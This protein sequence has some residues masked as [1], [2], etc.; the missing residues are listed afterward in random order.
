[1]TE[2]GDSTIIEQLRDPSGDRVGVIVHMPC[3]RNQLIVKLRREG[4]LW[5]SRQGWIGRETA[6]M[7]D[8]TSR[9]DKTE[10]D[11][12]A[13]WAAEIET[14]E[15]LHTSCGDPV[16][17]GKCIWNAEMQTDAQAP[18]LA[19]APEDMT[20]ALERI[21][22]LRQEQAKKLETLQEE[23][24][25]LDEMAAV[26]EQRLQAH[27]REKAEHTPPELSDDTHIIDDIISDVR[28]K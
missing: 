16:F 2:S 23:M 10:I 5:L 21:R 22:Q 27:Y 24:T 18:A 17:S 12:P 25:T 9:D 20:S 3:Q 19:S 8:C 7:L 14:G 28:L 15:T 11:I 13:E 26:E 6:V 1:M 4:G